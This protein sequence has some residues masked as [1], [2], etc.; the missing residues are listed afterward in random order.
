MTSMTLQGVCD[1]QRRFLDVC[2]GSPSRI[3]DS[4]VFSLS[5]IS[6]ELP[7]IC[8]GQYHLLGDAAYPL[9][10]YLLTPFKDYGNLT[11]KVR[12][13]NIKHS[14]TRVR[15]ENSFGIL[16]QRFR[17]LTRLDFFQ[18]ERMCKFVLACCTL[19]NMCINQNDV[20]NGDEDADDP[21]IADESRRNLIPIISVS[22]SQNARNAALRRLGE[23]KRNETAEDLWQ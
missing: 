18:V 8:C 1:A 2:V 16:K 9:R 4:R 3:H 22:R 21:S 23:V 14:Q 17:Q 13:Y 5:P 12:N 6:D 15:I 10:E 20:Y 19:H 11:H 7:G